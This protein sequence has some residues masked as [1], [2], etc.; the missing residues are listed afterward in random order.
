MK[1]LLFALAL[2]VAVLAIYPFL[3]RSG[4]P[5]A[6]TG[7]PWQIEILTDGSTKV[8]A[9]HLGNSKLSDATKLLGDD[10]EVAIIAASNAPGRLEMYF[11]S[12]RAGLLSGKII[13][14][15]NASDQAIK[16]WR[17]NAIKSDYV[18][19]G[20]AKKYF[21]SEHDL[22]TALDEVITGITFIPSVNLDEEIIHARF[23][24]PDKR[25]FKG[26]AEHFIYLRQGLDI[27]LFKDEKE[28]LQ[29]VVP[30]KMRET[31]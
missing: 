29:Y 20:R 19:T 21:L 14:N 10:M 24:K 18:A 2:L 22:V 13:L 11:R 1:S 30:E 15:T 28:V 16:D 6:L 27:A 4:D 12:Y 9:L 31:F 8:F 26:G 7:L 17:R 5:E 23:G 3:E 25:E